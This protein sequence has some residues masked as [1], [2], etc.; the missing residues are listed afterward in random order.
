MA[1]ANHEEIRQLRQSL[2]ATNQMLVSMALRLRKAGLDD[3]LPT[4]LYQSAMS[5]SDTDVRMAIEK[6]FDRLDG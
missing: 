3:H 1:D 6:E 2:I 5:I 4:E